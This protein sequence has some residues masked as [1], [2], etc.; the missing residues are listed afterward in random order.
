[1]QKPNGQHE[2]FPRR[3]HGHEE[4]SLDDPQWLKDRERWSNFVHYEG[5]EMA[6]IQR[7][8]EDDI[9]RMLRR[10]LPTNRRLRAVV[11]PTFEKAQSLRMH[12]WVGI[13]A[14]ML[15]AGGV[16]VPNMLNPSHTDE[17]TLLRP[18]VV[19]TGPPQPGPEPNPVRDEAAQFDELVAFLR[20]EENEGD[21][22]HGEEDV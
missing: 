4:L 17:T 11:A 22:H 14:M 9:A 12:L 6:G 7:L 10:A 19:S 1:M 15:M 5:Y 3:P 21:G 16:G 8:F 13:T 20:D 2:R 18:P